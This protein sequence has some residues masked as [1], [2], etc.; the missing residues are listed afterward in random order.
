MQKRKFM[1][2]MTKVEIRHSES[3]QWIDKIPKEKW[4]LSY[5]GGHRHGVMTIY[6]VESVNAMFIGIRSMPI[7][8][9][10]Q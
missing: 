2:W 10:I 8:T 3:K 1:R 4:A 7:T 6:Y 5:D 9:M